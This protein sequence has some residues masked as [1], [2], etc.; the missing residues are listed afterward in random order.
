MK[1][2]IGSYTSWWGPY[3]LAEK[4]CFWVKDVEDEFGIKSKPD[5]VHSFGEWLAHGEIKPETKV[6]ETSSWAEANLVH[7]WNVL[8]RGA[9]GADDEVSLRPR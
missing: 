8:V 2:K 3:Q 5:W 1:V 7:A 4:L 9:R 6:G